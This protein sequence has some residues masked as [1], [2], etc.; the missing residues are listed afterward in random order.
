MA[1]QLSGQV[2][3]A[4]KVSPIFTCSW[5][6]N[7]ANRLCTTSI[8]ASNCWEAHLLCSGLPNTLSKGTPPEL[9]AKLI[10]LLASC[11]S[12]CAP[13]GKC[14]HTDVLIMTKIRLFMVNHEWHTTYLFIDMKDKIIRQCKTCQNNQWC[15][16]YNEF[17]NGLN[18]P[19]SHLT[20]KQWMLLS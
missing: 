15:Y 18:H 16:G 5:H 14:W 8:L 2:L 13:L 20:I 7:I 10:T 4:N 17:H 3:R 12:K 19:N 6:P 1:R 9:E 11:K